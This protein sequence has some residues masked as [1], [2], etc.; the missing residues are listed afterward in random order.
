LITSGP[1]PAWASRPKSS[2]IPLPVVFRVRKSMIF[3][4]FSSAVWGK[5]VLRR[6]VK[7]ERSM[8]LRS[9]R[10]RASSS[11]PSSP[12]RVSMTR[13]P[14]FSWAS[15]S[16]WASLASMTCIVR[17]RYSRFGWPLSWM[18]LSPRPALER[19][20]RMSDVE[21]VSLKTTRISVPPP[22]STPIFRPL[23]KKMLTAPARIITPVRASAANRYF[24][25]LMLGVLKSCMA[26]ILNFWVLLLC[27]ASKIQC[28][29]NTAVKRLATRLMIRVT[30]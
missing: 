7:L 3:W 25:K 19:A 18:T 5:A 21:V 11:L 1:T 27:V 13:L 2:M 20:D 15:S 10:P 22:K 26:Q 12:F 4:A 16:C 24:M 29:T 14:S 9:L 28:E 6:A 23:P 8:A 17:I 30:A